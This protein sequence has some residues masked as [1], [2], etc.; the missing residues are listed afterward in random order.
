MTSSGREQQERSAEIMR[1]VGV[2]VH[3]FWLV[4]AGMVLGG[5]AAWYLNSSHVPQYSASATLLVKEGDIST[6]LSASDIGR[7]RALASTYRRLITTR[8]VLQEAARRL[9]SEVTA[10]EL[11]GKIQ[12]DVVGDTQ[13]LMITARDTDPLRAADFAN[14]VIEVFIAQTL[15][16]RL[17]EIARLEQ[18]AAAQ[19]IIDVSAVVKSQLGS[20]EPLVVA[21]SAI[22]AGSSEPSRTGLGIILGALAG[23]VG[24]AAAAFVLDYFRDVI[25]SK[26]RFEERF[27]L[28]VLGSVP[29]ARLSKTDTENHAP[30]LAFLESFRFLRTNIQFIPAPSKLGAMLVTSAEG[31][32]GKSTM[33]THLA[34]TIAEAGS[35]VLVIDADL[36]KSTLGWNL[37]DERGLAGVSNYVADDMLTLGAL[38]RQ[39]EFPGVRIVPAGTIPPNPAELL[40]SPR[41]G[42]LLNEAR[43]MADLVLIDSP[44]A[45]IVAD[46]TIMA[47]Q[48]DGVLFVI[49]ATKSKARAVRSSL[50]ALEHVNAHVF[51]VVLNKC[52][53]GRFGSYYGYGYG[54]GHGYG[55]GYGQSDG[56]GPGENGVLSRVRTWGARAGRRVVGLRGRIEPGQ[57]A[58]EADGRDGRASWFGLAKLGR[59]AGRRVLTR[60]GRTRQHTETGEAGT[61]GNGRDGHG[62]VTGLM[63]LGRRAGRRVRHRDRDAV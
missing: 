39:T 16:A 10:G 23:L 62:P 4:V 43:T 56:D 27:N 60:R 5:L 57:T 15:E 17:A 6:S 30:D 38:A 44:P 26:E 21:E 61:S 28:T 51:G 29:W 40:N 53:T 63:E 58:S 22:P 24:G 35:S 8:P 55:Y 14:T 25:A 33:V 37:L 20:L 59:R 7:S 48:V 54:Y 9:G 13:L 19:G 2:L 49:D 11:A 12:V 47:S 41:F 18:T 32:A 50:S 34:R 45:L 3:Y 1:Y 31:M 42:S 52:K 36:R 46:T